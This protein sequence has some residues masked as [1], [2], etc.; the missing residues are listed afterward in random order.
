MAKAVAHAATSSRRSGPVG[1]RPRLIEKLSVEYYGSEVPLQQLASFSVP[2]ARLLVVNPYDKGTLNAIEKAIR[3]S[4]L[5]LNPSNDG[6]RDPPGL[7]GAHRGT[8]EGAGEEGPD[9]AE[10]GKV[11]VRNARRDARHELESW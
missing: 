6:G 5:G 7:P 1:R 2:E 9:M 3:N 10:D 11:G 4:D 8:P